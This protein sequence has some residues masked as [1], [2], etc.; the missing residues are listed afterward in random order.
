MVNREWYKNETTGDTEGH[1]VFFT[2]KSLEN[3]NILQPQIH[4]DGIRCLSR[5]MWMELT[6]DFN[7]W[8]TLITTNK[9]ALEYP[10]ASQQINIPV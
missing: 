9:I 4:A 2:T 6:C 1:R 8:S 10:S 7:H 5:E 3:K